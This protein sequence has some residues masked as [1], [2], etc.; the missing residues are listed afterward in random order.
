M[1][2]RSITAGDQILIYHSARHQLSRLRHQ[3]DHARERRKISRLRQMLMLGGSFAPAWKGGQ[4]RIKNAVGNAWRTLASQV[5]G[6]SE[7]GLATFPIT[8]PT[9]YRIY[10][11]ESRSEEH[12]SEL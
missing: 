9:C 6:R 5:E 3:E 1:A 8:S 7:R 11:R 2:G 10:Q 4:Q 12:T